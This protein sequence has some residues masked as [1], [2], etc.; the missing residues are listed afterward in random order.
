MFNTPNPV[1]FGIVGIGMIADYHAQAIAAAGGRLIGVATRSKENGRAFAEKH[2]AIFSTTDV[3]ELVN[4]AD[5][6]V[7]CITTPSGA[8]LDPALAAISAGKH[9]VIEK[10]LEI[11][12]ER[13]DRIIAA[14]A[15]AGVRLA[16]IFQSRFGEGARTLKAAIDAGRFGRMVLCSAYVKWHRASS[17]YTGWKGTLAVDGGAVV[18]NQSIHAIDLLQW[19][20]GMPEEVFAWTTR[21]VHTGIEAED[22]A[23]ASLRFASGA[24]GAIES[25]TAL[26]PG[27]ARR[28]EIT[29]ETGS[30]SLEDDRIVRWDFREPRPEDDAI[31]SAPANES[32]RGGSSAANAISIEGHTRQ[33]QDLIAALRE[34]RPLAIEAREARN[35]VAI[36]NALYASANRGQPV[37]LNEFA[38]K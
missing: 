10:P 8:H 21:R 34:N 36:V 28:I 11:T 20:A 18:I 2:R 15:T 16:P 32:M 22:T 1:G 17:Y 24:L 31:R 26:W 33:L 9:V 3:K 27:W 29:G 30:V 13:A 38:S 37:S 5:V 35:A 6:D 4:R 23:A 19:F 12:T 7:I 25:S 14:A